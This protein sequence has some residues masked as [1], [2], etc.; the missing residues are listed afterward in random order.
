MGG[1]E[2]SAFSS[3]L[4]LFFQGKNES[5]KRVAA[6][7]H[8]SLLSASSPSFRPL[9]QKKKKKK[10]KAKR[11]RTAFSPLLSLLFKERKGEPKKENQKQSSGGRV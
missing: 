2:S 6:R 4:R 3:L 9:F 10:R 5:Q 11:R 8:S 1:V 7:G